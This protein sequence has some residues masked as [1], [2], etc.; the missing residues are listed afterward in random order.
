[1]TIVI[2]RRVTY[3]Y[4]DPVDAQPLS[5]RSVTTSVDVGAQSG[6]FVSEVM[7]PPMVVTTRVWQGRELHV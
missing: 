2:V 3:E 5:T 1:M 4:E 7:L 6:Q